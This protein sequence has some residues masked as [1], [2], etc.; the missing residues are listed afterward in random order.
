MPVP[1][2]AWSYRDGRVGHSLCC[3]GGELQIQIDN[4]KAPRKEQFILLRKKDNLFLEEIT[5][6]KHLGGKGGT[7]SNSKFLTVQTAQNF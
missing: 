5:F 6:E 3:S 2:S 1:H 4:H 7:V